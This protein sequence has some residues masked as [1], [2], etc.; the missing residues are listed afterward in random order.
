VN[1]RNDALAPARHRQARLALQI[2]HYDIYDW[3]VNSQPSQ[4]DAMKNGQR[5]PAVAQ[6]T[7]GPPVDVQPADGR[8]ALGRR[9]AADPRFDAP[10]DQTRPTSPSAHPTG[11][12]RDSMTR[13]SQQDLARGRKYCTELFDK[14]VNMGPY[15][16][17][18][19][20]P[21]LVFPGSEGGGGWGGVATNGSLGLIFVN[22]RHLGVIGQLSQSSGVLPS[23]SKAKIPTTYYTDPSG[24]PCNQPPWSE[25]VAVSTSTGDIVWR[26][27]LGEYPDLAA[28]GIK[29]TG[30]PELEVRSPRERARL[31][32]ATGDSRCR[33]STAP[34]E[35]WKA[36]LDD[37]VKMTPLTYLGANGKQYVVA[38]AANLRDAAFHLPART[39]PA[40]N[41]KIYAFAL[42]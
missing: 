3:D 24:Y 42:R 32:G 2:T 11:L 20:V 37:D 23:F 1:L 22:P 16:T 17:Y 25:L 4:F 30:T 7:A 38:V 5:V 14:S 9:G 40:P 29:G 33:A 18:G 31:H 10:G 6:M 26:M 41:T 28:K 19:M 35:L 8:T 34:A 39:G 13:R 36:T 27:P 21:S 15:T 12:T